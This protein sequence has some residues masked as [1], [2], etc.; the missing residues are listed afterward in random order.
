MS[1]NFQYERITYD[2]KHASHHDLPLVSHTYNERNWLHRT[3]SFV[4]RTSSTHGQENSVLLRNRRL[5]RLAHNGPS[6]TH[7]LSQKNP[8]H[9]F[10]SHLFNIHLT[11]L[12]HLH[13]RIPTR[14]LP[15]GFPTK[16]PHACDKSLSPSIVAY[17]GDYV[18]ESD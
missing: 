2:T 1:V 15:S 3:L 5:H 9:A 14:L 16:I 4:G 6:H 12:S 18:Q 11:L 10:P 8:V 13:L 7:I 17:C